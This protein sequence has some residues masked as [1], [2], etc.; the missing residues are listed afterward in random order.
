MRP[1]RAISL[2]LITGIGVVAICYYFFSQKQKSD[3]IFSG[4]ERNGHYDLISKSIAKLVERETGSSVFVNESSGS[5]ENLEKLKEGDTDVALLQSDVKGNHN[6]QLVSTLYSEV[7]HVVAKQKNLQLH[8]LLGKRVSIGPKDGG[9]EALALKLFESSG[10]QPKEIIWRSESLSE[11]LKNLDE[12]KTDAVCVV[13]GIGNDLLTQAISRSNL[14]FVELS[15]NPYGRIRHSYPFVHNAEIPAGAYSKSIT[16]ELPQKNLSTIGVDV[17]LACRP[18]LQ[19]SDILELTKILNENRSNLIKSHPL[20]SQSPIGMGN[21]NS[22]FKLHEGARQY[23][24]RDEPNFI[25]IWAE[26]MA[27]ILSVL[28]V[29]WATTLAVKEIIVQKRKDS[30]DEYFQKVDI[31]TSE[32]IE[33]ISPE[34]V[35]EISSELNKIRKQTIQKLIAEEL[36]ANESFVIFQRQL[37]TAQQLVTEKTRVAKNRLL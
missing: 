12:N 5:G 13:T 32:L 18:N 6:I 35:E 31:L 20:M 30:L 33:K 9:T 34:R 27:L 3:W 29:A 21:L 2:S 28:A 7:L 25:Q 15:K 36:S 19:E 17:I 10:I 11:S 4:G 23:Y 14:H 22:Q 1:I 16:E 37:H 24:E 8:E 26:P